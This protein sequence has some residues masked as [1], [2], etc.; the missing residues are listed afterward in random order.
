MTAERK[1][2]LYDQMIAWI[3][4]HISD[5]SD[6]FHTLHHHFGMTKEELHDHSIDSLDAFFPDAEQNEDDESENAEIRVAVKSAEMELHDFI[7][8]VSDMI[9]GE[10]K[11]AVLNWVNFAS[12]LNDAEYGNTTLGKELREVYLPLCFVQNNFSNR[13]LQES[14]DM[15]TLGSEVIYGAMMFAAGY[16]DDEVRDL[17]GR[18]VLM[19]GYVPLSEDEIGSL[20]VVSIADRDDILYLVKNEDAD[21]IL[22]CV[23]KAAEVTA[24]E[25]VGI[26]TL[27]NDPT[28]VGLRIKA[29][30]DPKLIDAI[31]ISC[32]A[33]T[34]IS[35]ITVYE[36]DSNTITQY[37]TKGLTVAQRDEIFCCGEAPAMTPQ[38]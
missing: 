10:D 28:T 15:E 33:S 8:E 27:L 16:T 30:T 23:Q 31:K 26:G 22:K 25:G 36:P 3:C 17:G 24:R 38:M 37:A 6:L 32:T 34:A 14:L 5:D 1:D 9:D 7:S 20:S 19:D 12:F 29:I 18:G 13:V 2:E 35:D 4:E 11:T 21:R